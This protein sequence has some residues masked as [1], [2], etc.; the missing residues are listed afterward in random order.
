MQD[1][2]LTRILRDW[3]KTDSAR[4]LFKSES[5]YTVGQLLEG[6]YVVG[7]AIGVLMCRQRSS[8]G[9]AVRTI[10]HRVMDVRVQ[11]R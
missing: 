1:N 9:N 6:Q 3:H 4:F 5:Y 11:G 10:T 8:T 7:T 2:S